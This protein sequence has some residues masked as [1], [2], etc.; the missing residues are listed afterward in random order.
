LSFKSAGGRRSSAR[1]SSARGEWGA[2]FLAAAI[3]GEAQRWQFRNG[4][5]I[6]FRRTLLW[7]RS[8][9][10]R[11]DDV[12]RTE[13]REVEWDSRAN[14]FSVVLRLKTGTEFE[15]PDYETRAAAEAAKGRIA[16]A[17]R[18]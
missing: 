1:S 7:R 15:T 2:T 4:A 8:E 17:L 18:Q 10:I 5:L 9:T 3:V 12:E 14:T 11:G 6:L 16:R 13:I